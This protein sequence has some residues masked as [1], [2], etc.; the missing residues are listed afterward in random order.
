MLKIHFVEDGVP[1]DVHI[2]M[3]K[4]FA[5]TRRINSRLWWSIDMIFIC[6]M[7]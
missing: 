5:M 4:E 2:D 6:H 3:E 7:A 1:D